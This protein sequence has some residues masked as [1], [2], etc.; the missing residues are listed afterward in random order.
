[1]FSQTTNSLK[2]RA[3]TNLLFAEGQ[4]PGCILESQLK[5]CVAYPVDL[6]FS[7]FKRDERSLN[8]IRAS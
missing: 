1:M 2:Q 3:V 6:H 5:M 4:K 7:V 8:R